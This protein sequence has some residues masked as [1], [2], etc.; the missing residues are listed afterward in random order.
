VAAAGVNS[1]DAACGSS[2][3][4]EMRRGVRCIERFVMFQAPSSRVRRS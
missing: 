4:R 2:V 3:P 1:G